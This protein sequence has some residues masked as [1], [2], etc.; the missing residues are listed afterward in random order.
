M[1]QRAADG[2]HGCHLESMTSYR[3]SRHIYLKNFTLIRSETMVSS[4]F[5]DEVTRTTSWRRRPTT[6][7]VAI[8]EQLLIQKKLYCELKALIHFVDLTAFCTKSGTR[9]LLTRLVKCFCHLLHHW[10]LSF[11]GLENFFISLHVKCHLQNEVVY[12]A[13]KLFT[14]DVTHSRCRLCQGVWASSVSMCPK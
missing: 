5:F 12:I 14:V 13:C 8:W 2:H 6:R 10:Q 9:W 11:L 4:S 7:W 3:P 1:Q